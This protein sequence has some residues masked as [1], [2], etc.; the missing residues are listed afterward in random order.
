MTLHKFIRAREA[1]SRAFLYV[2]DARLLSSSRSRR[3]PTA[4]PRQLATKLHCC[5]PPPRADDDGRAAD[6]PPPPPR[7]WRLVLVWPRPGKVSLAAAAAASWGSGTEPAPPPSCGA[8]ACSAMA[9]REGDGTS[10][11]SPAA[12]CEQDATHWA[13]MQKQHAALALMIWIARTKRISSL[14][15][16]TTS[17]SPRDSCT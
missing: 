3:H 6:P 5:S 2:E 12:H 9:W 11:V 14:G 16:S 7:S 15:N 17:P 1:Q 13:G 8:F 10:L 4:W